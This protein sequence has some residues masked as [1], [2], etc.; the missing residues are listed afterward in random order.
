MTLNGTLVS[1]DGPV[2]LVV[3]LLSSGVICSRS[4][5]LGTFVRVS[6][7][8]SPT[9]MIC[10]LLLEEQVMMTKPSTPRLLHRLLSDKEFD[11]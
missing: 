9:R 11:I 5:D 7:A 6:I 2:T 1:W 10:D 4:V 3:M 8:R